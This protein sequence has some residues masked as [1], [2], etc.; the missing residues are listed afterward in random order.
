MHALL[1]ALCVRNAR[2]GARM[3]TDPSAQVADALGVILQRR[4][5]AGLYDALV[6]GVH[7][8]LDAA[9]YPVI[10]GLARTGPMTATALGEEIGLD[11]SVV[12]RRAARLLDAGLLGSSPD[13][14][15]AR[16]CLLCLTPAGLDAV[17]TQPE[18]VVAAVA[19]RLGSWPAAEQTE[20]AE[21]MTRF[22]SEP[23]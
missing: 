3:T 6:L 14:R 11:R 5:R 4:F 9:A 1:Y 20:L 10:S 19:G 23:L 18:R 2:Y 12:S 8:A 22:A 13:P 16:A 17:S 7:E 21:L 15:D